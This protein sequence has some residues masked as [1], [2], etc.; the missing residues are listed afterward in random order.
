M[1]SL[2]VDHRNHLLF[3]W[4]YFQ[5]YID[6]MDLNTGTHRHYILANA[7]GRFINLDP[8]RRRAIVHTHGHGLYRF[9][10]GASA[11]TAAAGRPPS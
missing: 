8:V 3:A 2:V 4:N 9:E 6:V 7:L 1:R 11:A 5:G 10:Y